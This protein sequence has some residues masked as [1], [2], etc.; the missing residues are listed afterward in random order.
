MSNCWTWF[1]LSGTWIL[2]AILN[3]LDK[4][5]NAVIGF[6]IFSAV[7][8]AALGLTQYFCNKKG[9]KGKGVFK[10]VCIGVIT[11]FVVVTLLCVTDVLK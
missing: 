4:R 6:N 5:S 7:L 3:I 10:W 1:M 11:L 2:V 8:F 9:E